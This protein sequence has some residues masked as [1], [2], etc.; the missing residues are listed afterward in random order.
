MTR[1]LVQRVI[2]LVAIAAAV[3]YVLSEPQIWSQVS[4]V[5]VSTLWFVALLSL[6]GSLLV[7]VS[8]AVLF[9]QAGSFRSIL[10]GYLLAQPGKYVPGGVVQTAMQL[11]SANQATGSWRSTSVV[12]VVHTSALVVAGIFGTLPVVSRIIFLSSISLIQV[13][14]AVLVVL[15]TFLIL[16]FNAALRQYAKEV[17][18]FIKRSQLR[19]VGAVVI[20]CSAL[21]IWGFGFALVVAE[22]DGMEVSAAQS[23][24][25]VGGWLAGFVVFPIPAGIGIREAVLVALFATVGTTEVIAASL[26]VRIAIAAA[27]AF[28][29]LIT[30]AWSLVNS[31]P[32]S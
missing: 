30:L 8:W 29:A 20:A 23:F 11:T 21:V 9:D 7:A 25:F 26:I 13:A 3:W 18:H 5:S 12:F 19:F 14:G 27:E 16:R 15:L 24:A 10:S 28:L 4:R 6:T 31:P 1:S 22:L 32:E 2:A 17:R